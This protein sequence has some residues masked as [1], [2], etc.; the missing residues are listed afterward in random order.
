VRSSAWICDFSSTYRTTARVVGGAKY[1]PTMSRT[2]SMNSGSL[3]SECFVAVR[4]QGERARQ[5]RVMAV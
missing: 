1:K 2:L 3:D 4:L 5:I